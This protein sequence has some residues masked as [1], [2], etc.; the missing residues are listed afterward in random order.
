MQGDWGEVI[1]ETILDSSN[2][3]RGV[4]YQTQLNIKDEAG[5][6]RRP[7]VVLRLPEG[8][9]IV[10]DSKVSLTAFVNYTSAES[11]SEAERA[12]HLAAHLASVRQ[13]VTELGRKEYQRLV[14]REVQPPVESP[15]FVIMFIP[16]EP[17]FLTAL[18][19]D[20]TIWAD[21]YEKKVIIS[22]PTNLF[23]LLKL[24]DDLWKRNAQSRNTADIVTYG[25][26][27]YDQLVAF[28]T[29]LEGVG[30][31]L[32]KAREAYD[33]AY[34]RLHTGNDNIVRTGARGGR[35]YG[36]GAARRRGAPHTARR[37]FARRPGPTRV[38]PPLFTGRQQRIA[39]K[40]RAAMRFVFYLF[41]SL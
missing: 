1:L 12:R 11:E 10:I 16:N 39:A 15:D 6:N 35:R 9:C 20:P 5:N 2:L 13:H 25:T 32:G 33:D 23:A 7:D 8:K 27:L 3:I 30:A 4:H 31:A 18:Q 36:R 40:L 19:N 22:S 14:C 41:V 26:K 29:S 37:G 34:K 17:A 28:T 38:A 21:A 24:V